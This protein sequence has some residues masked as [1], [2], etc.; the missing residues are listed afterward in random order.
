MAV[1]AVI[2]SLIPKTSFGRS[3]DRVHRVVA[4]EEMLRVHARSIVAMV[5]DHLVASRQGAVVNPPGDSMGEERSAKL[6]RS[7]VSESAEHSISIRALGAK[8]CPTSLATAMHLREEGSFLS[9]G[10]SEHT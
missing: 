2:L 7:F 10:D 8:P 1:W 3:I 9:I 6:V 5:A 4:E